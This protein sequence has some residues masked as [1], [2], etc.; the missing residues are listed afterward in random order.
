MLDVQGMPQNILLLR[1]DYGLFIPNITTLI[2]LI[3]VLT[4]KKSEI[5]ADRK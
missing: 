4:K 2:G 5:A 1:K 3:S